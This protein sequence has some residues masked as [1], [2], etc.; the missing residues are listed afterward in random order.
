MPRPF[1]EILCIFKKSNQVKKGQP[2][3]G[4]DNILQNF[5]FGEKMSK[6]KM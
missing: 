3:S 1:F 2:I 6:R 4:Q 5:V